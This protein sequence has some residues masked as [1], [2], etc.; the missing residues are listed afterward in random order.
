MEMIER[1][2]DSE[3]TEDDYLFFDDLETFA[4]DNYE[5][6]A[7]ENQDFADLVNDDV[8]EVCA[9]VEHLEDCTE[10]RKKLRVVYEAMKEII[11]KRE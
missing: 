8:I 5:A 6:F 4:Y 7:E 11:D 10:H 2:L 3:P 1:F 9:W